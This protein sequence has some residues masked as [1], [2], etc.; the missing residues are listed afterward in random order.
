MKSITRYIYTGIG[1]MV[2]I[3]SALAQIDIGEKNVPA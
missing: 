2:T 3:Q 1:A